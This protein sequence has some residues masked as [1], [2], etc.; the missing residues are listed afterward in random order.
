MQ[1]GMQQDVVTKSNILKERMK[2]DL[3]QTKI[4]LKMN[5]RVSYQT[6]RNE[7]E[8]QKAIAT[9]RRNNCKD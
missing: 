8:V 9:N 6:I 3:L 1:S 2:T 4:S 7:K 5:I